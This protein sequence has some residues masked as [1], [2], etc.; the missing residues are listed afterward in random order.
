MLADCC[1]HVGLRLGQVDGQIVDDGVSCEADSADGRERGRYVLR[2]LRILLHQVFVVSLVQALEL[3]AGPLRRGSLA[4][5]DVCH[6]A[7]A[8]RFA[9]VDLVVM[10]KAG[11]VLVSSYGADLVVGKPCFFQV[12]YDRCPDAVVR[13]TNSEI[14]S[15]R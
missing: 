1:A 8:T 11:L 14:G 13:V 4:V 10:L 15:H 12:C 6:F 9:V 5:Q 7:W 3:G 2:S